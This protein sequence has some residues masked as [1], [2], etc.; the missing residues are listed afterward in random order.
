[1][2]FPTQHTMFEASCKIVIFNK[3]LTKV[4]LIKY[5]NENFYGLPGGHVEE[6]EE[7]EDT[8]RRELYEETGIDYVGDLRRTYFYKDNDIR[9]K[10][11]MVFTSVTDENIK[12]AKINNRAEEII[13]CEWV[14]I[15]DVESERFGLKFSNRHIISECIERLSDNA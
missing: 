6:N 10:I 14:D 2:D 13:G 7:L 15:E 5:L 9:N 3:N 1:M 12:F 8:A 4:V 11:V